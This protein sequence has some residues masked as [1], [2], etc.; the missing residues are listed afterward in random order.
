MHKRIHSFFLSALFAVSLF[1]LLLGGSGGSGFGA[2][3]VEGDVELRAVSVPGISAPFTTHPTVFIVEDTYQIAFATNTTGIAWVE[4]GGQRFN[5]ATNGLM[6]WKSNYHKITLPQSVMNQ[7]DSY[8]I[9]FRSLTDRPSYDPVPGATVSRTYPFY[10]M[11]TDR[12]PVFYC[13]SD[14]HGNNDNNVKI[15]ASQ[16]Y[17][18]YVF[19]GDY[20]STLTKDSELKLFLEYTGAVTKGCKPTIYARGN[21]EIRGAQAHNLHRVSGFSNATGAYYRVEMPGIFALVLD[22]GEDKVDSHEAYGGTT[23]FESYRKEQTQWLRGIVASREWEKYPVRMV[24]CHVPFSYY[25]TDTFETVYKEWTELLDQMGISL[26]ISGHTHKNALQGPYGSRQNSSPNYSVLICSDNGNGDYTYS[27]SFVTVSKSKYTIRTVLHDLSVR[28]N[29]TVPVFTNA[30]VRPDMESKH[31]LPLASDIETGASPQTKASV[32]AISSP[33]TLHPTV[34]AVEDGYQIIFTTDATGMAWVEVGGIKYKDITTGNM[35]WA[36]KYHKVTV[37]RIPLDTARSYKLCFQS[38]S[39]RAAYYPE[40]GSTVSR[41][42]PFTPIGDKASPVLLCLSDF[43]GLT[44]EAQAVSQ[45]KSFDL[46]FIGGDYAYNGNTEANIRTLLSTCSTITSGTKPVIYS[47]GN[48]EVRG[49]YAYLLDQAAPTSAEGKSY[50]TFEQNNLFGIVLDT[51]ED[52]ADSNSAYGGTI[53]YENFRKEQTQW[54]KEVVA[55]GKWKDYPTRIA[56]AQ[57]PITTIT[58]AEFKEDYAQW[59]ELLDQMGI[60]LLLCCNRGTH[61]VYSPDNSA[62]VSDPAFTVVT[63][64]DVDHAS[65]KYAG[66]FVTLGSSFKIET[67]SAQKKIVDTVTVSNLTAAQYWKSSDPYLLFDFNN[68]ISARQRYHSSAYAGINF[69]LKTS[70]TP[71]TGSTAL[72]ITKGY[73]SF[74]PTDETVTVNGM[75]SRAPSSAKGNWAYKPLHYMT[76]ATDYFQIRFKIDNAVSTASNGNG[77]FRLDLDCPNDLDP[78][79]D[80]SR[81]YTRY[82]K[83]FKVADVVGK[84]YTVLTF[85]LN[86]AEYLNFDWLSLVHPVFTNIKSASGK[87]ATFSIDYLYIG[88]QESLPEQDNYLYFDFTDT[89]ADRERYDSFTYNHLNFDQAANWSAYNGSPLISVSDGALRMA[90]TPGNTDGS[91]S[92]RSR[93]DTVSTLHYV[94]GKEDHVQIRLRIEDAVAANT[95]GMATLNMTLDR[96]NTLLSPEGKS[97]TW[98]V[99]PISFSVAE[100]VNQDWFILEAKLDD[101]EYLGSDWIN[102][103]HPNFVNLQSASG[104]TAAIYIDY[105]YIGP[106]SEM[107]RPMYTVTFT[108]ETGKTLETQSVREG[109]PAVYGGKVPTKGYDNSYHYLFSAWNKDLSKITEDTVVS[110]LF[111]AIA[112]SYSHSSQDQETHKCA[113]ACGYSFTELHLWNSGSITTAPT[114]TEEGIHTFTC[115]A[116][117]ETKTQALAPKGHS[118][119]TDEAVPP[120]CT[121][122][123]KTEGSHCSVC[124]TVL[125]AQQTLPP[126]GHSYS[127]TDLSPEAHSITCKACDYSTQAP[128]SYTEAV[129]ICGRKESAQPL[130]DPS[131]KLNHSLNLASDISINLAVSK[132]VLEGFDLTSLYVESTLACYEGNRYIGTKTLRLQAE[133]H[134]QYYYFTLKGLTAVQMNDLV[135]SVLYGTKNGQPYCS[136]VDEYSIATYAY[137]QLTN[138]SRPTALKTLCADLLRYGTKAQIYKSYR[139]DALADSNMTTLHKSYLSDIQAVTFGSTNTVLSDTVSPSVTWAGKALNLESKVAL[140]FIFS[141]G[142]FS[143]KVSDLVLQISYKDIYGQS[144]LLTLDKAELYSE[145]KGLYAFTLDTLLAAELRT[146][147]SARIYHGATPVSPT[148]QYSADTYG[149]NKTGT[150]LELCKALFAYSDSAKAYFVG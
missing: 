8:K 100:H 54:L 29:Y 77:V 69:D 31:P 138:A 10:P 104:K 143:G 136:P 72:N 128:H 17:D 103:I 120:T 98:A 118:A 148:L 63:V 144:K 86:S 89:E 47:R 146:V 112:H 66:S 67:A 81:Y 109:E 105:I 55:A 37:P 92:V 35:N 82:E 127:Y 68:D 64:A 7:A 20:I 11:P 83:S 130:T 108:D 32:P 3:A 147:V 135:S 12:D 51:G 18:V 111:T 142:S 33:Y 40:H 36:S 52:K 22:A 58:T 96:C 27:G 65:Y 121:A 2:R 84:G 41:T 119:V 43:R 129:C 117:G 85:P 80:T 6:N 28:A 61:T 23:D 76:K 79:A 45:T 122:S 48:R 126:T 113:C 97:R 30:Y 123:G 15:S 44:A 14:Q 56:F 137:S 133:D 114:C 60:S 34:F 95:D 25:A 134:G 110:P 9:C 107:P 124:G 94:P 93:S 131:L 26:M 74:S 78:A 5:D 87:T 1:F 102:V 62:H 88:P 70:W 57:M 4:V 106:K 145:E 21:H 90:V 24:F 99:I 116:C 91:Y 75:L 39:T 73:L 42:Y 19:D 125:V 141:T 140:K 71:Q 50:Y 13:S 115:T 139:T 149:N 59:T 38:M 132:S 16:N 101:A 46:L 49:N 53:A 150:L